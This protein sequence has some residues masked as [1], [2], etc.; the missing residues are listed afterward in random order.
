MGLLGS[1]GKGLVAFQDKVSNT[2]VGKTLDVVAAVAK[3]PLAILAPKK[4]AA[5]IK[6]L[7]TTG[8][9]AQLKTYV[10]TTAVQTALNVGTVAAGAGLLGAA[11]KTV[12]TKVASKALVAGAVATPFIVGSPT[13]RQ[14]VATTSP[15]ELSI[16]TAE[17]IETGVK[18]GSEKAETAAK[19]LGTVAA[20]A[21]VAGL[22][23]AGKEIYD[24]LKT[25]D[26]KV[27]DSAGN[28]IPVKSE[29]VIATAQDTPIT[30]QTSSSTTEKVTTR[31]RRKA[32]KREVPYINIKI[33]NREDNDVYDRKVYKGGRSKK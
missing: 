24:K 15:V 33:D 6:E 2:V 28:E 5:E 1:I 20:G 26:I 10:K 19:V 27:F 16:K 25:S 7:R 14:T 18:A 32:K 12:A 21:T 3:N 29:P 9:T 13:I 31:R 30:P 22:A 23:I 17:K 4:A 11:G 8:T